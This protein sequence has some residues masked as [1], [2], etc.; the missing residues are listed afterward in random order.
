MMR[1]LSYWFLSSSAWHRSFKEVIEQQRLQLWLVVLQP[2]LL[3]RLS[4]A[5]LL[6]T[7]R[8][9]NWG[10]VRLA[11]LQPAAMTIGHCSGNLPSWTCW[12]ISSPCHPLVPTAALL[13][14]SMSTTTYPKKSFPENGDKWQLI[15]LQ[16]PRRSWG[17]EGSGQ[18]VNECQKSYGAEMGSWAEWMKSL[19]WNQWACVF[20]NITKSCVCTDTFLHPASLLIPCHRPPRAQQSQPQDL[21]PVE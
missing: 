18:Y 15:K 2:N 20:F 4:F 7:P 19:T 12:W 11:F 16:A 13:R 6:V 3:L 8:G 17:Q 14:N 5:W 9:F 21:L 10:G 1:R